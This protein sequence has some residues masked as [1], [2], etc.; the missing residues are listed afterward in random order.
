[1]INVNV[2][3]KEA[4]EMAIQR[5]I[6]AG[7]IPLTTV[8]STSEVIRPFGREDNRTPDIAA[9]LHEWMVKYSAIGMGADYDNLLVVFPDP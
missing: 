2:N 9:H 6:Q 8:S 4:H 3:T 1:V 7:A 5:M